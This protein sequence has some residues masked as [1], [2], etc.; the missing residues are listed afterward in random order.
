M[1]P[2]DEITNSGDEL[3]IQVPS[4]R[5][6][7]IGSDLFR[8][9]PVDDGKKSMDWGRKTTLKQS[10]NFHLTEFGATG[11]VVIALVGIFQTQGV[12]VIYDPITDNPKNEAHCYADF[13]SLTGA[14]QKNIAKKIKREVEQTFSIPD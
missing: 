8:P 12:P 11:G 7:S 6:N 5:I 13:S 1:N 14:R 2:G 4:F 9:R 10:F 3:F